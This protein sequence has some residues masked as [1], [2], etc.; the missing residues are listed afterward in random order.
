MFDSSL[1][2]DDENSPP[3]GP[4]A[5]EGLMYHE[6]LHGQLLLNAMDTEPWKQKVC[7]CTFDIA[8]A[9]S[10]HAVIPGLVDGY[11]TGRAPTADITVVE[12]PAQPAGEVRP[13]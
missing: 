7:Q 3:I 1:V 2:G 6:F 12:L 10:A 5:N 11:Y 9:D 4:M 8:P 13:A